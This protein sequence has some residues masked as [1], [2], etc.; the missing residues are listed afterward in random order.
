MKMG[1]NILDSPVISLGIQCVREKIL[2]N[3]INLEI[4]IITD[5]K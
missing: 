4:V 2:P 5:M 3:M 1:E